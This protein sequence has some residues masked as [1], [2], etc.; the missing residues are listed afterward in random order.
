MTRMER[1]ALEGAAQWVAYAR[2]PAYAA[3]MAKARALRDDWDRAAGQS[4]R[5]TLTRCA[6]DCGAIKRSCTP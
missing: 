3:D 6:P 5:C 1:A 2:S 4:P